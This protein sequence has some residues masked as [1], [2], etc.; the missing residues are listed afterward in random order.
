M[1][2]TR[3]LLVAQAT[4]CCLLLAYV[5]LIALGHGWWAVPLIALFAFGWGCRP[6]SIQL[7]Q[8]GGGRG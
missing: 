1:S 6:P 2:P 3:L 4:R 7:A 8:I 5:V